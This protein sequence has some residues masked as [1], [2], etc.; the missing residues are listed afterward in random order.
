MRPPASGDHFPTWQNCGFYTEPIRD[1]TAVH[2]LEH[3][4]IWIAYDPNVDA[5][6][7]DTIAATVDLDGHV[8]AAPYPGL[9]HPIV[10][11]AWQRQLAVMSMDRSGG[12]RVLRSSTRS[13][14]RDGAGGRCVVRECNRCCAGGSRSWVCR[15]RSVLHEQ[16]SEGTLT[17]IGEEPDEVV[18]EYA[19]RGDA[20]VAVPRVRSFNAV[21]VGEASTC[22]GMITAIG[23]MSH[24]L[25]RGSIIASAGRWRPGRSRR[26]RP[27]FER[28]RRCRVP[29]AVL[30]ANTKPLVV[31]YAPSSVSCPDTRQGA[32]LKVQPSPRPAAMVSPR[33]GRWITRRPDRGRR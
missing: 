27:T 32:P 8:L 29:A 31:A 1:E 14:V 30:R 7:R 21:E 3:G 15:C 5:A 28:R 17:S 12:H 22:L 18:V 24:G 4:A 2:S 26:R 9:K 16:L 25:A 19:V 23:A 6:T 20:A 33:A 11:T 13:S 10:L